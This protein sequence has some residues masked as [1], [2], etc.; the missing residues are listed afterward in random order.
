M[1]SCIC[2]EESEV[3]LISSLGRYKD[4][5]ITVHYVPTYVCKCGEKSYNGSVAMKIAKRVEDAYHLGVSNI[6]FEMDECICGGMTEKCNEPLTR[7]IRN[8]EITLKDITYEKCLDCGE[9]WFKLGDKVS[10]KYAEAY[11]LLLVLEDESKLP[12]PTKKN[13]NA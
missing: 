5:L 9:I 12:P 1:K 4:K 13:S 11:R 7:I 10:E 2:G 6:D 8:R 3:K